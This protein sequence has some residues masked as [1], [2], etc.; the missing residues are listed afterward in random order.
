MEDWPI[1]RGAIECDTFINVPVLKS[2]G[3]TGLTLSMKNLMGVCFGNRGQIHNDIGKKL[4]D[5]ADFIK[6]DL[7]VV[8]AYRVLVRHGPSGGDLS[9]VELVETI[10]AG[11]DPT[12]VDVYAAKLANKDPRTIPNIAEAINRNYGNWDVDNARILQLNA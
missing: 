10:I 12:L 11:T 4:V 9:D 7:T 5:L 1:F 2:H 6:P 8:D 3:L